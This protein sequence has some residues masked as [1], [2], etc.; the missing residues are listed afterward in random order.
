MNI[1]AAAEFVPDWLASDEGLSSAAAQAAAMVLNLEDVTQSTPEV[2]EKE[3]DVL[4]FE[5]LQQLMA[6]LKGSQ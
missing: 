4:N 3:L 5:Q 2:L 6:I 1:P